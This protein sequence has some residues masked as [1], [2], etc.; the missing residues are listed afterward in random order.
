[1]AQLFHP[2]LNNLCRT[3]PFA[4]ILVV[5][6]GSWASWRFSSSSWVTNENR[7]VDQVVP[8]SHLHHVRGLG[9]DCRFCHTGVEQ[10][11]YAGLPPT[12]TCMTCHSQIWR[13]AQILQPVRDSWSNH[14]PIRWNRVNNLPGYVYFNHSAHVNNGVGC[15][16]CHGNVALMP[17]MYQA[18]PLQMDWCLNC[19]R[20]PERYLRPRNEIF[21]T[22]YQPGD[23]DVQL[24]LG[25]KLV[26]EYHILSPRM[27][28][29]C[30]TCH[31]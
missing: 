17:L 3:L 16:S 24:A 25:R 7:F 14:Q 26:A 1:M 4:V 23:D 13:D 20:N 29:S 12:K 28:Q 6:G 19:H 11:S 10:S 27:M 30:S 5:V 8:F 9:I 18:A 2:S 15:S 31:R 22:A 21:N